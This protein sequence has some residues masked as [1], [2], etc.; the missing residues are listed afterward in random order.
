MTLVEEAVSV[1]RVEIRGTRRSSVKGSEIDTTPLV[2]WLATSLLS[3]PYLESPQVTTEPSLF[4]AAKAKPVEKIWVTPDVSLLLTLLLSPP[5]LP[6]VTTEPSL[7]S[8]A[9]A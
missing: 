4:S 3:P 7:F 8:A 9:K 6:Q 5:K 2:N 1:M